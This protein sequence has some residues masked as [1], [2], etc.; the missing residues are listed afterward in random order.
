MQDAEG[1]TALDYAQAQGH[2]ACEIMLREVRESGG[3]MMW[4]GKGCGG[5]C[6][7]MTVCAREGARG[8]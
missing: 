6:V 5:V 1:R 8:V 4:C 3:G 2:T 7:S